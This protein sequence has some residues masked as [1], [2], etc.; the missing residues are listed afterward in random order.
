MRRQSVTPR[1]PRI[2]LGHL[3]NPAWA[4]RSVS[5]LISTMIR[6]PSW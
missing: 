1:G 3:V 2:D 6:I 4:R 5:A